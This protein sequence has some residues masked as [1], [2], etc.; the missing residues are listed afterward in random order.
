MDR[1]EFLASGI[2]AGA[3]ITNPMGLFASER[4]KSRRPPVSDR[5]F[6]SI[7]VEKLIREIKAAIRDPEI[8]WMFEN[9]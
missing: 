4:F 8:A 3:F 2:M 5:T 6:S 9:C 7:E 1:R